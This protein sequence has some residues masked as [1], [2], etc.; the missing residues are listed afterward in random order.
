MS[1]KKIHAHDDEILYFAA[2]QISTKA[3]LLPR[4]VRHIEERN[5]IGAVR[6]T[7]GFGKSAKILRAITFPNNPLQTKSPIRSNLKKVLAVRSMSLLLVSLVT[8]LA[9]RLGFFLG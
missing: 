6:H 1:V 3:K 7:Y 9:Y 5:L 8:A 2:A 4:A